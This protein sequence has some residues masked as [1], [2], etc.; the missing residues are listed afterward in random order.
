MLLAYA[1]VRVV[2]RPLWTVL[3]E[4]D[5]IGKGVPASQSDGLQHGTSGLLD[6]FVQARAGGLAY[7][8]ST[9]RDPVQNFGAGSYGVTGALV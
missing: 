1:H 5:G 6:P 3:R 7:R 2:P 4:A 9:E 8:H